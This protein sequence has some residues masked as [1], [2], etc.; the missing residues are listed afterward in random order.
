MTAI[1]KRELRSFFS[2]PLGYVF[3]AVYLGAS[4]FLFALTTL[5]SQTGDV[6]SFSQMM[7][8]AFIVLLPL[9]TMRSFAEERRL[10]TDQLILTAPVSVTAAVLGKFFASLTVFTGN[11]LL[12]LVYMIPLGKYLDQYST[13]NGAKT[14]GCFLA[15]FLIGSCFIAVGIFVSSVTES[16]VTAAIGTMAA[17]IFFSC[18]S[19]FNGMIDAEW[20]RTV[21]SWTSV[22]SRFTYFGYGIFDF[23]ALVYY[24]SFAAVFLFLAVRFTDK[25]RWS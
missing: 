6:S 1:Y 15:V 4:G 21:L 11:L 20:I 22:L 5:R 7:I 13:I 24:V 14:F 3:T 25:R 23:S 16:P 12:S 2:T 17:L 18:I 8:F 9:L 10:K 19:L